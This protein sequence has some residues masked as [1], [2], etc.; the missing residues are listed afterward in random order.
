VS[1]PVGFE[2]VDP[3]LSGDFL[4]DWAEWPQKEDMDFA[5]LLADGLEWVNWAQ[6]SS[7][8]DYNSMS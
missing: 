8:S 4:D 7:S 6:L 2:N 3:F 1:T 5:K